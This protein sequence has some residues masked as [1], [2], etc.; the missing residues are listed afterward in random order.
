MWHN[1]LPIGSEA[2]GYKKLVDIFDIKTIPHFRWSYASSKTE[3]H[4]THFNDICLTLYIYP[5]S[6]RLGDNVLE[7]LEFA[8]KNEG[9]NLFIL[10]HVLRHI[11]KEEM[12]S[13]IL[14]KP[15]G[16]YVRKLWYLFEEFNVCRLEVAD[17]DQGSYIN[18]LDPSE[19][20]TGKPV[21]SGRHRVVV[22]LLGN[23]N[24]A[25]IV[26]KTSLLNEF[27]AKNFGKAAQD[28]TNQYDPALLA[29]AMMYLYTKETMSSWEIER[30]KPD[31]AKLAKFVGLLHKADS[32]G[33][34]S[35]ETLIEL[36]KS[37]VDPRFAL[38]SY[39][40]FQNYVGE[41]PAMG[42][43]IIHYICP[44]PEN[45]RDLMNG[46][47]Y[48]FSI[49]EKSNVNPVIVA[50]VLSFLFVFIHP[51]E[52]GNGRI[53]RFLI[54][55]VLARLKLTPEGVVFPISAAIVRD[56]QLYDKTLE[57]FSKPLSKLILDYTIDDTGAM[58]VIEDTEDYYRYIDLTTMAEYLF[59]CVE[60]T[61]IID[62]RDELAFLAVYDVI[63]RQCKEIIDMPDQKIDLFIRCVRQN[64]GK[65]SSRKKESF[66]SMLTDDEILKMEKI[67]NGSAGTSST[68]IVSS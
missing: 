27:E 14:N 63:K 45:V 66:F 44:R 54:H 37:I 5:S 20:Y 61:M 2:I 18:L 26:R 31:N 12:T 60:K 40:T 24:F 49:M 16:K 64:N 67:I 52:D 4:T 11:S 38:N 9:V 17:L 13:Y 68:T 59:G 33:I 56:M 1:E 35:Q 6:Y 22:N 50:A 7:N 36:Q 34:L 23:L 46:L 43:L 58:T 8:L 15:T 25:P 53:H 48:S 42:R 65:L 30:E 51:F 62:F 55:Y 3:K 57:T 19:Y 47:I 32:I 28:L 29:R 41:E 39:R 10:K 21:R